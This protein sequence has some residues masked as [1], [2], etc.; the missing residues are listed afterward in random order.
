MRHPV[1]LTRCATTSAI[2]IAAL[3]LPACAATEANRP[4]A[5]TGTATS[6]IA[7]PTPTMPPEWCEPADFPRASLAGAALPN[8][9]EQL[10]LKPDPCLTAKSLL[11]TYTWLVDKGIDAALI[12]GFQS[13]AGIEP[14]TAP[15]TDGSGR[16]IL[17]R[18]DDRNG[19][20]TI[21]CDSTSSPATV[22]RTAGS[23]TLR[24]TIGNDAIAVQSTP[25]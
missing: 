6:T 10:T 19:W 15:L 20:G 16:C 24:F 11:G 5:A 2:V 14:W 4:D 9:G 17:I 7:I 18:A 12:Q 22:E 23:S 1:S 13:V 25:P 3:V 8:P 21:A